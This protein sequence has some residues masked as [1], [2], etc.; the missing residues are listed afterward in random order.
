MEGPRL[1][2]R[3]QYSRITALRLGLL[4]D[5]VVLDLVVGR[6]G[7][8]VPGDELALVRKRAA[9]DYLSCIGLAEPG[10]CLQLMLRG[11]IQIDHARLR[12]YRSSGSPW[13]GRRGR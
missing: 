10:Q 4:D 1:A 11:G 3:P 9:A 2:P 7:N 5:D 13:R 8:H 6:L 12:C